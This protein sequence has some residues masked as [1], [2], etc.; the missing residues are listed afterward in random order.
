MQIGLAKSLK[1]TLHRMLRVNRE[2]NDMTTP[3]F[4]SWGDVLSHFIRSGCTTQEAVD[5]AD[6][7]LKYKT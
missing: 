1:N 2:A 4:I 7:W 6:A 3:R 5:R